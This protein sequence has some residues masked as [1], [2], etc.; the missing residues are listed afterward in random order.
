MDIDKERRGCM[1]NGSQ[2]ATARYAWQFTFFCFFR[3]KR[4]EREEKLINYCGNEAQG[5]NKRKQYRS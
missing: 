3:K 5:R 2:G 4:R 1:A